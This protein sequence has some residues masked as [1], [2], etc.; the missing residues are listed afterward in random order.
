MKYIENKGVVKEMGMY[1]GRIR[2]NTERS[3]TIFSV[4]GVAG[5]ECR[6]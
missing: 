2:V 3:C 1:H 4:A 6:W 5:K